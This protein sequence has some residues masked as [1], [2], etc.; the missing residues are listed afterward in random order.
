[1][2]RLQKDLRRMA[3][4]ARAAKDKP[5]ILKD[6]DA[7]KTLSGVDGAHAAL[8]ALAF[9][10]EETEKAVFEQVETCRDK[11][12]LKPLA[13]MIDDK[14]TRRRFRLHAQIAHAFAAIADPAALEPL[15]DLAR[16]EDAHVVA[17][18]ADALAGF[19]SA[20]HAKRVEP[21]RRLIDVFESTYNLKSRSAPRTASSP[22]ARRTSGRSTAPPSARRCRRSPVRASCPARVS[23]GTGGTSTRKRRTGSRPGCSRSGWWRSGWWRSG[24]WR[25]APGAN[26]GSRPPRFAT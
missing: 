25:A 15:T 23:S 13:A 19:R 3:R 4:G 22:T 1:V 26:S 6:L 20:P 11:S 5:E 10:D 7:L 2:E 8:E 14:E 21:V 24:W 16:S 18:A 9:D 17:A 12:L